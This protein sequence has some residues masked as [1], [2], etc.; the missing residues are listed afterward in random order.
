MS[1]YEDFI[2]AFPPIHK[3]PLSEVYDFLKKCG[4][5]DQLKEVIITCNAMVQENRH[6][7]NVEA[8]EL[9]V[10]AT[11]N[12]TE[13]REFFITVLHYMYTGEND[14]PLYKEMLGDQHISSTLL[15]MKLQ[16][17]E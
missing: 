15:A 5:V 16:A 14:G 13:V 17:K 10:L 11:A 9:S 12:E 6:P 3:A 2:V 4:W 1:E 7:E 8:R